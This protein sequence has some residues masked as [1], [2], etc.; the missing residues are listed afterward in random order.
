MNIR[1]V[2]DEKNALRSATVIHDAA[3]QHLNVRIKEMKELH[4][5]LIGAKALLERVKIQGDALIK[6]SE[7][8]AIEEQRKKHTMYLLAE[9]KK[10]EA[11]HST[12]EANMAELEKKEIQ[13]IE[14]RIR[15]SMRP[16]A[17]KLTDE[18]QLSLELHRQV[19]ELEHKNGVMQYKIKVVE[20]QK[21]IRE[22]EFAMVSSEYFRILP[23]NLI[24]ERDPL[25]E[26]MLNVYAI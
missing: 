17:I 6:S 23:R 21:E 26:R 7:Y 12:L 16:N 11:R 3:Q 4:A 8:I 9:N 19:K 13:K 5:D 14:T 24:D 25:Q 20:L 18:E 10:I 1:S 2:I 22:L 15:E